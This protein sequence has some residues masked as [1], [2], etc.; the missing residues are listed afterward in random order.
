MTCD[1][2]R[3]AGVSIISVVRVAGINCRIFVWVNR[4]LR[5]LGPVSRNMPKTSIEALL[6]AAA[7]LDR[8]EGG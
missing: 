8:Y 1:L 7:Y 3:P 2:K 4:N 6:E 5:S